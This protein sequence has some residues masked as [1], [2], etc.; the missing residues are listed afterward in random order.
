MHDLGF[1]RHK[2]A[3]FIYNKKFTLITNNYFWPHC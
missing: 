1:P 2:Q 3:K